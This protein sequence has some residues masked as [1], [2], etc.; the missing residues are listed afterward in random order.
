MSWRFALIFSL[1]LGSTS[2]FPEAG[3]FSLNLNSSRPYNGI[4]KNVYNG[5]KLYIK[6]HCD[7][8]SLD[9]PQIQI[10]WVL[11]E[12]VCW[13][14]YLVLESAIFETY[15]RSP[16]AGFYLQSDFVNKTNYA[17]STESTHTCDSVINLPDFVPAKEVSGFQR[18]FDPDGPDVTKC[19]KC[20]GISR[21]IEWV[22]NR[23]D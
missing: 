1:F 18:S 5:T 15:Y 12:T 21:E 13:N 9:K 11:R 20:S 10:G 6:V 4:V 16:N 23:K 17:K 22:K 14:E 19:Q 2:A 3:R 8:Q 7:S